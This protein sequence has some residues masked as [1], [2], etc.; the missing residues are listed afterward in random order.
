MMDL[1]LS[2]IDE[3]RFGI[4][5]AR[6]DDIH[7]NDLAALTE[8]CKANEVVLLI[9]RCGVNELS[10]AQGLI[11]LGALLTDTLVYYR[12]D[13]RSEIKSEKRVKPINLKP[14][15]SNDDETVPTIAAAAFSNF[16]GHYHSDPRLDKTRCDETYVDWAV[17]L[18]GKAGDG[19]DVFLVEMNGTPVGFIITHISPNKHAEIVLQAMDPKFQNRGLY[20]AALLETVK[21]YGALGFEDLL[22]STQLANTAVQKACTDLGFEFISGAYTFHK[23][24]D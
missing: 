11:R 22:I 17:N 14:I 24:F 16:V 2:E 5:T 9:A 1:H 3:K 18:C 15:E 21:Y 20:R 4:R 19:Y 12:R 8:F 7:T 6:A 23:W 13:M 10:A